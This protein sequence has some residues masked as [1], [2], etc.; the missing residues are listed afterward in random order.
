MDPNQVHCDF[1]TSLREK[2]ERGNLTDTSI[3]RATWVLRKDSVLYL[4]RL[5]NAVVSEKKCNYVSTDAAARPP[6]SGSSLPLRRY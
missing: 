6:S 4:W 1:I 3:T 5:P 2:N